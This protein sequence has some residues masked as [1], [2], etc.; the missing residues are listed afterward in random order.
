MKFM[1][2]LSALVACAAAQVPYPG[3]VNGPYATAYNAYAPGFAYSN[4]GTPASTAPLATAAGPVRTALDV[5]APT[6]AP[7]AAY[8]AY[9]FAPY[10]NLYA[11]YAN[12]GYPGYYANYA[13]YANAI[14]AIAAPAPAIAAPALSAAPVAVEAAPAVA[15]KAVETPVEETVVVVEADEKPLIADGPVVLRAIIPVFPDDLRSGSDEIVF[16]RP[17]QIVPVKPA[18]IKEESAELPAVVAPAFAA[19]R[20][21]FFPAPVAPAGIVQ[22]TQPRFFTRPAPFGNVIAV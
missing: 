16:A 17:D 19:A 22:A 10:G 11:G 20:S 7:Y 2:A 5:F 12:Y 14:P 1:I 18:V 4:F 6:Y 3:F 9:N 8:N 13:N 15:V 21:T